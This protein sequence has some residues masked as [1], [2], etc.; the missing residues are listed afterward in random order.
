MRASLALAVAAALAA[1]AAA[2]GGGGG[3][4]VGGNVCGDT[5]VGFAGSLLAAASG[6]GLAQ[7]GGCAT[8]GDPE[9]TTCIGSTFVSRGNPSRHQ[10]NHRAKI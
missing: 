8:T 5:G 4:G 2:Q 9:V 7:E 6:W 1:G 10:R 3:N